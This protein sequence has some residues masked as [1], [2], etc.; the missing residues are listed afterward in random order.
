[1]LNSEPPM[2][3]H[4]APSPCIIPS[5]TQPLAPRPLASGPHAQAG[6]HGAE[7]VGE[8]EHEQ[9]H[10]GHRLRH[11][12]CR[13]RKGGA[14]RSTFE[15]SQPQQLKDMQAAGHW[16]GSQERD[17]YNHTGSINSPCCVSHPCLPLCTASEQT[18]APAATQT[19]QALTIGADVCKPPE[20]PRQRVGRGPHNHQ[21]EEE[22]GGCWQE[23]GGSG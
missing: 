6:G 20:E 10:R 3:A 12:H 2:H 5:N 21:V 7:A 11:H 14:F 23:A 17:G 13:A 18:T 22:V 1:M 4:A 8:H 16:P 9:A 15:A 19:A